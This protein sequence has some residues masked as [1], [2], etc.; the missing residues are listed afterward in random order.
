[1]GKLSV[2]VRPDQL[3]YGLY[4]SGSTGRPKGVLIEHGNLVNFL[5]SLSEELEADGSM[6]MLSVTGYGFDICYL[7]WYLP[8]I[9]GGELVLSS[10]E[11]AQDGSLLLR[12]VEQHRPTHMQATPSGWEVLLSGGWANKEGVKLLVGGES[13]KEELK[14]RL[15]ALGAAWNLYGPTETT[16]WSTLKRLQAQG[17]VTLGRPIANTQIYIRDMAGELQPVGV[18]GELWIG[19]KGVARGYLNRPELTAARFEADPLGD[20]P[21]S[22]VY[23]T[24][25]L[26]RWLPDGEIE[27][28]GRIDDQ[29]KVRGH[30]IEPGEIERVLEQ[31]GLVGQ[32]VVVAKAD[33][34]GEVGLIGYVVGKSGK[35]EI[36][37]EELLAYLGS[38]LPAY[39]IPSEWVVLEQW[40]LTANG[41]ID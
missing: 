34:Q 26:G 35:R 16:I 38:R 24:G 39:M 1:A 31:S 7:E 23:R 25:D 3:A 13:L 22:R 19:G 11:T 20:Q 30:R 36:D 14:D 28:Q 40:P 32:A 18:G 10:R 12:A 2:R 4:T 41:K 15:T 29:V 6:R 8:L 21:G 5:L 27:Y 9:V 17:S 37:R 33:V